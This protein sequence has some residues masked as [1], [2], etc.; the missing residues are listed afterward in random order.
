MQCGVPDL[1]CDVNKLYYI[2]Y[3]YLLSFFSTTLDF[4]NVLA[5]VGVVH[6]NHDIDIDIDI[7]IE[8][9][10][11]VTSDVTTYVNKLTQR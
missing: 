2:Y 5:P 9:N 1:A 8:Y 4:C 3:L 10:C 7:D 11:Y 6:S